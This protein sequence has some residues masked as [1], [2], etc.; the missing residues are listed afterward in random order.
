VILRILKATV[1]LRVGEENETVGLD[2]AEHGERG[3]SQ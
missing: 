2:L 3:Y 1:G